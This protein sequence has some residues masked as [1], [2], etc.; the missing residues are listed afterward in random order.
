MSGESTE[1]PT[2]RRLS[3][4]KRR[5]QIARSRDLSVAVSTLAVTGA[6]GFGGLWLM[7]RVSNV[8]V[9][10]LMRLARSPLKELTSEELTSL[11]VSGLGDVFVIVGPLAAIAAGAGVLVTL[12]QGGFNF[13]SEALTV[14]W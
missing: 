12:M 2:G 5:G 8:I 4:A 1:K 7:G 3:E 14:N 13:A 10:G 6:L 9:H 11:V